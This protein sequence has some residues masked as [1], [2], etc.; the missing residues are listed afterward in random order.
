MELVPRGE[1]AR[2]RQA[3]ADAVAAL[4]RQLK[5]AKGERAALRGELGR[6]QAAFEEATTELWGKVQRERARAEEAQRSAALL[7]T[8]GEAAT[9]RLWAKLDKEQ[10][11]ADGEQKR[12]DEALQALAHMRSSVH[13][14]RAE[15]AVAQERAAMAEAKAKQFASAAPPSVVE[16]AQVRAKLENESLLKH[17]MKERL[18]EQSTWTDA[19][20][21]DNESLRAEANELMVLL[22]DAE[23]GPALDTADDLLTIL[24]PVPARRSEVVA[25]L[26]AENLLMRCGLKRRVGEDA[27][28]YF[29]LG[30]S[31]QMQGS[32]DLA[33]A[34]YRKVGPEIG[35][36]LAQPGPD[37]RPISGPDFLIIGA[38]RAGTT[39]LKRALSFHPEVM[40]L[41]GEPQ[42]FAMTGA[43]GPEHYV[44]RFAKTGARFLRRDRK[45]RTPARPQ[46]PIHG[47]KST[48]YLS[49]AEAQISL[50]AALYPKAR[51]VCMVRDPIARAWSHIKFDGLAEFGGDLRK[52]AEQPY[53]Q[54]LE[55]FIRHGRYAQHL[56]RWARHYPP[57]QIHLVDFARLATD[58]DGVYR[59]VLAH[60][61]AQADPEPLVPEQVNQSIDAGPP[62]RLKGA[63]QKAYEKERHD[64][65][66]LR[67]V[68]ERAATD[69]RRRRRVTKKL[70]HAIQHNTRVLA[71]VRQ[72]Q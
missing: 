61:G 45:E 22:A 52:L 8:S 51:I 20:A 44:T 26:L 32:F 60:I 56:A 54:S 3:S 68:M 13:D 27:A 34:A 15:L 1:L 2:E 7:K 16:L 28:E 50:C 41:A 62:E 4:E 53:W 70:R 12:A 6:L 57:E 58:P 23:A 43:L 37:G 5:L 30:R 9:T 71:E 66:W 11:R 40:M 55:A 39:W 29:R 69:A 18:R 67:A 38:P 17:A 72:E 36:F 10:K 46:R 31:L 14:A 65:P 48:T 35:N 19:L 42:F 47:E 33:A 64:L 24:G 59:D 25:E 49:M 21:A 63:L